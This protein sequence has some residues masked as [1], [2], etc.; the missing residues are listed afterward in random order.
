MLLDTSA[1]IE[2][3]I[4]SKKGKPVQK[5]LKKESCY[6]SILTLAEA[7][8]WCLKNGRDYM[9]WLEMTKKLTTIVNLDEK[10]CEKGADIALKM[11]QK[12]KGFGLM[13]GLILASARSIN[14][15]LMTKDRDFEGL[16]DVV[17]I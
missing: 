2:H 10:I 17:L 11:Q 12:N 7:R 3:F 14:Q 6:I 9:M 5:T 13:D 4:G 1:I 16:K 8:R 15:K